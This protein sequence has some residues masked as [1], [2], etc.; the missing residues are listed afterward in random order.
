MDRSIVETN[1]RLLQA[2]EKDKKVQS[3]Q[4]DNRKEVEQL[5]KELVDMSESV[6]DVSS[7][8]MLDD[9]RR[10]IT[11]LQAILA[12]T[13]QHS[14]EAERRLG[15]SEKK[16]L[17]STITIRNM[18]SDMD[19]KATES[20]ERIR[21][22]ENN[23]RVLCQNIENS[24]S[25]LTMKNNNSKQIKLQNQHNTNNNSTNANENDIYDDRTINERHTEILQKSKNIDPSYQFPTEEIYEKAR[26]NRAELLRKEMET[27][28]V[29]HMS[30]PTAQNKNTTTTTTQKS[31]KNQKKNVVVDD[32]DEEEEEAI[33]LTDAR[34]RYLAVQEREMEERKQKGL[35]EMENEEMVHQNT[36]ENPY[37]EDLSKSM[38]SSNKNKKSPKGSRRKKKKTTGRRTIFG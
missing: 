17:K 3:D 9:A 36:Y 21:R 25:I 18:R 10:Q 37:N 19:N 13:H 31:K 26:D 23:V 15:E 29:Q 28:H 20:E 7:E 1:E 14:Q 30:S 8:R 38:G 35:L 4:N 2:M 5:R 6:T 11:S 32:D 34:K 24:N 16:Y 27:W 22:L 12:E 33:E